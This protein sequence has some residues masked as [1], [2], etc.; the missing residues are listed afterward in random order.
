M[1][2]FYW[3][4]LAYA[5]YCGVRGNLRV[6]RSLQWVLSR[7]QK[8]KE[9]KPS[10]DQNK[11]YVVLVPVL[12][13]QE[14]I[15]KNFS[16]FTALSGEYE[17]IYITTQR[18]DKEER[19]LEIRLE[20]RIRNI[21]RDI[22][23]VNIRE[24]LSGYLPQSTI[25]KLV[26]V[27]AVTPEP[28]KRSDLIRIAFAQKKHT[29]TYIK[30]LIE[31]SGVSN[32]RIIDYPH[33]EG[34]MAH[35][36]NYAVETLAK[37]GYSKD[38][39]LLI[40]NADSHVS[41]DLLSTIE[42]TIEEFPGANVIQ[43]S[44]L[45]FENFSAYPPT[46]R[47]A[48]LA[49]VAL[50]QSRW[51][52]AHEIPRIMTQS[53]S[54]LGAFLEGAH[55]VGHGLIIRLHTLARVGNFP[56]TTINEDLPLGYL[57]RLNGEVIHPLP[58]FESAESPTTI[59]AMFNQYETWGYGTLLYPTYLLLAYSLKGMPL[60]RALLW[61]IR[62]SFRAV[63][64]MFSSFVWVILFLY[65]FMSGH[66]AYFLLS[67]GAFLIYGPLSFFLLSGRYNSHREVYYGFAAP[68]LVIS[69]LMYLMTLPVYLTHSV[70]P[71]RAFWKIL[72]ARISTKTIVKQKT[73][74]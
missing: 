10:H 28:E 62:Y 58:L 33:A 64:W 1:E 32:V 52:L 24:L 31:C 12:R 74:R 67:I 70:G 37:E 46:M 44:A 45:F 26:P 4:L 3:T 59:R 50:L 69:S 39:F 19:L 14:V 25:S 68:V 13:E 49:A 5:C 61:A 30:E 34:V 22:S 60:G 63:S 43:Q 2:L 11:R 8:G 54:K 18:E 56:T 36:L 42:K 57:L 48:F 20:A 40:Y 55:V 7:A 47:G 16:C 73:E 35:Q 21:F 9:H 38:T 41:Q 72:Y 71:I 29:R 23:A 27:L 65:P 6:I 51:T 17:L 15:E 53:R 66:V